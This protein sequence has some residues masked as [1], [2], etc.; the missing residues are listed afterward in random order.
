MRSTG[1]CRC[2]R[3]LGRHTSASDIGGGEFGGRACYAARG[4]FTRMTA[5]PRMAGV[6]PTEH[7]MRCSVQTRLHPVS[8][9]MHTS[10]RLV[11]CLLALLVPVCSMF[12][13]AP[14]F[15]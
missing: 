8:T 5:V 13:A 12:A 15:Q 3:S 1:N 6:E 7:P 11:S 4:L 9:P 10:P 14:V 2:R